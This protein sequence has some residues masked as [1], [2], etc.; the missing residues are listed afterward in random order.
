MDVNSAFNAGLRGFQNAEQMAAR[1]AETIA[2]RSGTL[3][4]QTTTET[5]LVEA[6][7]AENQAAASTRVVRAADEAAGALIDTHA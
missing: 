6:A 7:A 4:T 3:A 1:S 2:R 5:A